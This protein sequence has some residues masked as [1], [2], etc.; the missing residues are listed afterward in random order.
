MPK[1]KIELN[2]VAKSYQNS[3]FPFSVMQACDPDTVYFAINNFTQLR[4]LAESPTQFNFYYTW[5]NSWKC[6]DVQNVL[7]NDYMTLW[8]LSIVSCIKQAI[9]KEIYVRA[10]VNE[11]YVPHR[12]VYQREYNEHDILIYGYEENLFNVLGYDDTGHYS[13]TIITIDEFLNAYESVKSLQFTVFFT[14]ANYYRCKFDY[15]LNLRLIGDYIRSKNTTFIHPF[16]TES[17]GK[18]VLGVDAVV[19]MLEYSRRNFMNRERLDIR[20]FDCYLEHKRL[21]KMRI[22][23]L[24]DILNTPELCDEYEGVFN[25]ASIIKNL[26]IKTD[27]TR[28]NSD[29]D[30]LEKLV[31]ENLTMEKKVLCKL[32]DYTS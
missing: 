2:P 6:I 7:R 27:I 8:N 18:S 22:R 29:F 20:F 23:L 1:L 25:Q 19:K 26:S 5:F 30:N 14:A 17:H 4:F 16:Y 28:K 3:A 13:A 24:S 15:D 10:I 32:L 31:L 11:Y 9:D 21:M 12:K